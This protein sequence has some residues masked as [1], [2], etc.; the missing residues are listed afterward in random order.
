MFA[1]DLV[2]IWET[3]EVLREQI[4]KALL[5]EYTRKWRVAAN[6]N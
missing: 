5:I 6:V 1:D 3:L 4:E 2:G